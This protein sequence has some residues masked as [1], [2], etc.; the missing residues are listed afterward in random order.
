MYMYVTLEVDPLEDQPG[1]LS[2]QTRTTMSSEYLDNALSQIRDVIDRLQR[3]IPDLS[4]LLALLSSP[5][6]CL[7][8][9][10]PQFRG[11]NTE[12]LPDGA[13][14]IAKHIP[15]IQ[16][17]LLEHVVP[18]WDAVLEEQHAMLLL[19]QYF[20]PDSFSYTSQ[21]AG[22]VVLLAYSTI[23]SQ[24]LTEFAIKMLAR[25]ATEY[26]LDRLH[27]AVFGTK[28]DQ[29]SRRMVAWEDCVRNVTVVPGKVAN[30][31]AGKEAPSGLEHGAYFNSL[32]ARCEHLIAS[33]ATQQGK[34]AFKHCWAGTWLITCKQM[35]CR[36]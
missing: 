19:K 11:Y 8:L 18:T 7:G 30:A 21:A 23:L 33:L 13:V 3:P 36:P 22:D 28:R 14:I 10:P 20:C 35:R 16:R 27:V 32:C 26:P 15:A 4:N 31:L 17:A 9:L 24:P 12:P 34:G 6:D 5:L 1:L 2:T 29:G 25:L